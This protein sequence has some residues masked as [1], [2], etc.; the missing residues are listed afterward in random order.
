MLYSEMKYLILSL[1]LDM[2]LCISQRT[3]VQVGKG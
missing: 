2:F 3:Q 1:S